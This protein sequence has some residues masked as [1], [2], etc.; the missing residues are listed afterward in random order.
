M[1]YKAQLADSS[2]ILMEKIIF[3]N[4][5]VSPTQLGPTVGNPTKILVSELGGGAA[6]IHHADGSGS[7]VSGSDEINTSQYTQSILPIPKCKVSL[8]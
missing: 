7:V 6:T 4:S 1:L 3:V 5:I 8:T 2:E